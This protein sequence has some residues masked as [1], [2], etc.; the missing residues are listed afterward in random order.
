VDYC[1]VAKCSELSDP[2]YYYQVWNKAVGFGGGSFG[3]INQIGDGTARTRTAT[4][5]VS[6]SGFWTR[7]L[8]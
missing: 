5:K 4:G 7:G 6:I 3:V 2:Y 1:K 8:K